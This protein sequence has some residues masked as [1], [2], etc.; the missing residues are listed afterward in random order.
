MPKAEQEGKKGFILYYDYRDKLDLLSDAERGQL[1]TALL[2]YGETGEAEALTGASAMAFAF[3][4]SQ[5]DR[6]AERYEKTC[7]SR[8]TAGKRGGRP[9]KYESGEDFS[10]KANGFSEKQ[11]KAKKAN[12]FSEKQ[13][14]AKKADKD[15]DT[16]TDKDTDT[17]I[18][19][20]VIPPAGGGGGESAFD[21]FWDAYPRKVGKASCKKEWARRNPSA[22]LVKKI[23][24]SLAWQKETDRW[25]REGGRYIPNPLTWLREERWENEPMKRSD[26]FRSFDAD[27][28]FRVSLTRSD[29]EAAEIGREVRDENGEK[30][31]PESSA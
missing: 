11:E 31:A 17:D 25:R 28:F 6:D 13:T 3:I 21:Q 14:K 29:A 18:F 4:R 10:E 22:A 15:N 27:E 30:P 8:S 9:S 12:G 5:M 1:L 7:Q 24:A 23:L 2:R 19:P 26:R 20:P 16:D